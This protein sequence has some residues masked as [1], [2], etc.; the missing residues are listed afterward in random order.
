[1]KGQ[2]HHLVA[3]TLGF[4]IWSTDVIK[5]TLE[6]VSPTKL[7]LAGLGPRV[8]LESHKRTWD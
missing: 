3:G 2:R 6:V 1:M 8:R 7:I 5:S 4:D